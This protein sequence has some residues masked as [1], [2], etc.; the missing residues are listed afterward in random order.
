MN[1][2]LAQPVADAPPRPKRRARIDRADRIPPISR[3]LWRLFTAYGRW[4]IRRRFH[5]VR[6]L[7]GSDPTLPTDDRPII[8]YLNHPSWWDPMI[9]LLLTRQL[10]PQRRHYAPID[11]AALQRYRFFERLGFFG[12]EQHTRA[13]ADAFLRTGAAVL[14]Q[15]RATLWV[16]AQGQFT[17][18]RQRPIHLRPGVAHLARRLDRGLVVP[19]A[20]EYT[21]WTE[22]LAEALVHIGPPIDIAHHAQRDTAAWQALLTDRLTD[23]MDTLADAAQ[24]RDAAR[25]DTL[26]SGG[27]GVSLVYDAWRALKA[28]LTGRRFTPEHGGR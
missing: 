2:T 9:G 24:Q 10:M 3:R 1:H 20:L 18:V 5:A 7:K 19:V 28:T 15:P 8:I 6:L 17:D 22:P 4:Y 13:G 27:A 12:V 11:A 21:L 23:A 16:T 25:F 14:D 26:L